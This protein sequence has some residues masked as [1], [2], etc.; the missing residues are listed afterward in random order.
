MGG[1]RMILIAFSNKMAYLKGTIGR[2]EINLP[3][4]TKVP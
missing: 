2:N 4:D 3:Y 1:E